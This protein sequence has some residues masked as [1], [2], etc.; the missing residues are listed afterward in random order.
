MSHHSNH[1]RHL[2]GSP[3]LIDPHPSQQQKMN[4]R[5]TFLV[6]SNP[7]KQEVSHSYSQTSH[8][9]SILWHGKYWKMSIYL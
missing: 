4:N 2:L 5:F 9:V 8:Q 7:A 6:Q 3:M 1:F